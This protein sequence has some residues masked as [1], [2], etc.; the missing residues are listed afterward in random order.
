MVSGY[1][2]SLRTMPN[3]ELKTLKVSPRESVSENERKRTIFSEIPNFTE[4]RPRTNCCAIKI[5]VGMGFK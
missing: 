1:N 3:M 5:Q 2:I 4:K